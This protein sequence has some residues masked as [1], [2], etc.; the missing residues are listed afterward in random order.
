[1]N[2]RKTLIPRRKKA[3][4]RLGLLGLA[5]AAVL[6]IGD[7]GFTAA[8]VRETCESHHHMGRTEVVKEFGDLELRGGGPTCGWISGSEKGLL[9]SLAHFHWR[10][11]WQPA[12]SILVERTEGPLYG[13]LATVESRSDRDWSLLDQRSFLF[14]WVTDPEV[15]RIEFRI[16]NWRGVG[17]EREETILEWERETGETLFFLEPDL[18]LKAE[19]R[20]ME[21]KGYDVQGN[22]IAE[23]EGKVRSLMI[24]KEQYGGQP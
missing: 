23:A 14:G 2:G 20:Y 17:G 22:Q 13:G 1:M 7:Y 21:L 11:G 6:T 5:V 12:E 19:I 10:A 16:W 24:S 8:G 4:R 3:L 18:R 15:A 9:F